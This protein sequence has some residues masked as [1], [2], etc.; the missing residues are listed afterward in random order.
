MST[1]IQRLKG[2]VK[3]S[4]AYRQLEFTRWRARNLPRVLRYHA[5][6]GERAEPDA[7][8]VVA[9]LRR[10]GIAIRS[11]RDVLL[12]GQQIVPAVEASANRLWAEASAAL[13]DDGRP[14][15]PANPYAG[16]E[17][18]ARLLPDE[19]PVDSPFVQLALD[20][21]LI[22]VASRYLGMQAALLA[23]ELWWDRPTTAPAKETQ[24]WHQDGDDLM[25]V[26]AFMYLNDVDA[27]T[28]P[29]CF[30]PRTQP[31]GLRHAVAVERNAQGRSTDEQ[32]AR[33]I[34]A[35]EWRV[36]TGAAGTVIVCDTCGYHKGLKPT[37]RD[38]LMLMVQYA[39]GTPRYPAVLK[40]SGTAGRALSPLQRRVLGE[41]YES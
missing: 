4:R 5:G 27:D 35:S 1:A 39:S 6:R 32:M 13:R 7:T 14:A 24:L 12:T 29:F 23:V 25:N 34:P 11:W 31:G 21:C 10:E 9:E 33:A 2:R 37:C 8:A 17:Y 36:C 41:I 16:K 28:G 40:I 19:L 38:R 18:K 3:R 20:P 26:K 15:D 30:I 22:E